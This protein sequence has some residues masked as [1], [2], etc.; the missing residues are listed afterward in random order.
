LIFFDDIIAKI[1]EIPNN[2]YLHRKREL[3]KDETVRELIYKGYTVPF[4]IDEK[5]NKIIVLGIFNQNI[6]Q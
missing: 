4:Y 1:K 2:P 6:W 3:F 5:S